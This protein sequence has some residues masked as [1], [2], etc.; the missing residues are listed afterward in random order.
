MYHVSMHMRTGSGL[1]V[2]IQYPT[3]GK[4]QRPSAPGQSGPRRIPMER[5][6][7][8]C[9]HLLAT[10][11]YEYVKDAYE[12]AQT[13]QSGCQVCMYAYLGTYT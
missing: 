10:Y 13:P 2:C 1:H 4:P 9:R 11:A 7:G 3:V 8:R 6:S 5:A 12:N